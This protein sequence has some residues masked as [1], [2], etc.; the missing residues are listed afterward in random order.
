MDAR[1]S[2]GPFTPRPPGRVSTLVAVAAGIQSARQRPA[3][4]AARPGRG[5]VS[6]RR[7]LPT[8]RPV[9][10]GF[11]LAA[12]FL[13]MVSGAGRGRKAR[14]AVRRATGPARQ[15]RTSKSIRSGISR[16]G[17]RAA[18]DATIVGRRRGRAE[19][20]GGRPGIPSNHQAASSR[21]R[22]G[23]LGRPGASGVAY[24]IRLA[25]D[26]AATR[27][28]VARGRWRPRPVRGG[29]ERR[30]RRRALGPRRI[31]TLSSR[32]RLVGLPRTG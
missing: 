5:R 17:D 20:G 32:A 24:A 22:G 4:P 1:R 29:R 23:A 21:R 28:S 14:S 9:P 8:G 3:T 26:D 2:A 30:G 16:Y 27:R 11:S 25:A 15:D 13:V 19:R 31:R 6:G 18:E 10:S 12:F 7:R